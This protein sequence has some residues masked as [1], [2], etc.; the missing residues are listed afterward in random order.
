ML[1]GKHL[2]IYKSIIV[3][4]SII[5]ECNKAVDVDTW[6]YIRTTIPVHIVRLLQQYNIRVGKNIDE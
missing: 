6:S 3:S 2:N 4:T 1:I 5:S